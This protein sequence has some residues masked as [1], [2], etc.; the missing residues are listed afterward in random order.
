MSSTRNEFD[1]LFLLYV[2][3]AGVVAVAVFGAVAYAVWRYRY[4]EG[5]ERR[6]STRSEAR[7]E[8]LVYALVV[9]GVIAVVLARTLST[10][11]S[12]D[13]T[14][15]RPPEALA[16]SVVGSDAAQRDAADAGARDGVAGDADT[17]DG[18]VADADA[19]ADA[20]AVDVLAFQW[21]W[22]FTYPEAGFSVVGGD[23]DPPVLTVPLDRPVAFALR[24]RDVIHAFW[25]P[26][27]RFKRDA[28]P[29]RV[30]RFDLVFDEAG[31]QP[32]L[33]A[34]FC[35]LRHADMRFEVEVLPEEEFDAWLAARRAEAAGTREA[36]ETGEAAP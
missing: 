30:N 13:A 2:A 32:G 23:L 35:G 36:A 11:S 19:A 21:G 26:S 28:I 16:G 1:S 25:V 20:L 29:G 3:I 12:V 18:E 6:P 14:A 24:A 31:I 10:E 34:E 9:A 8:E 17:A 4:R 33:C 7:R 15:P 22:R 5:E 27:Q